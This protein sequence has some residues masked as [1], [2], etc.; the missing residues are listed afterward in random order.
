[1]IK[2]TLSFNVGEAKSFYNAV[3]VYE[4]EIDNF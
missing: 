3:K 1:M 2:A 4:I